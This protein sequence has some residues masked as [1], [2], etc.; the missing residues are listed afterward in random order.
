VEQRLEGV[1]RPRRERSHLYV[2]SDG[3]PGA[4]FRAL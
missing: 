4:A 3:R 1:F 2:Y